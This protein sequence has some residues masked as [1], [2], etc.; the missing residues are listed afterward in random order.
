MTK[1]SK[2]HER[3]VLDEIFE[4]IDFKGLTQ[5]EILGRGRAGEA[6]DGEIA[7]KSP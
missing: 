1:T 5:E 2:K 6:V 7:S 4:Q 3:D